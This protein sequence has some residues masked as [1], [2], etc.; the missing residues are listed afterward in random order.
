[1]ASLDD[2]DND[3][4][5]LPAPSF[6]LA[7]LI[8]ESLPGPIMCA[9]NISHHHHLNAL[10]SPPRKQPWAN[11]QHKLSQLPPHHLLC[12]E[13][14]LISLAVMHRESETDEVGEDGGGAGAGLDWWCAWR[15]GHC[16]GKDDGEEVWACARKGRED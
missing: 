6:I 2:I 11:L 7:H 14:I 4:D 16:A 8:R 1:M 13:D 5:P 10:P 3:L 12:H 9:C 15:W